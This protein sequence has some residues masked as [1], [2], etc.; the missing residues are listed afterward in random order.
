MLSRCLMVCTLILAP[1]LTG[2]AQSPADVRHFG[3][4]IL[5]AADGTVHNAS[6]FLC[7]A[8]VNGHATG[9]VRVFA[10]H[11]FLNGSVGGSVLVFGGNL[12]L[13]SSA[14]VGG[15]V[16]IF[17]GHLHQESSSPNHPRTV[18]PP[19]IFLPLI[20]VIFAIIGG[21]IVLTQRMVRGPVAYPPL[22][23]L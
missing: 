4:N 12:T 18:L 11:V 13:T 9:G 5:V 23:R 16:F 20:L 22:P 10:G 8:E 21:L 19:I 3:R 7:S 15:H 14:N 6:C 17:G 1:S 2:V